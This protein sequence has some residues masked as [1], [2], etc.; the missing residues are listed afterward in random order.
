MNSIEKFK[1][2]Q[3]GVTI[4]Q[5]YASEM[6]RIRKEKGSIEIDKTA[7]RA[8][9]AAWRANNDNV[10]LD[11]ASPLLQQG[12]AQIFRSYQ[13][14]GEEI[15]TGLLMI[16]AATYV[17]DVEDT[18]HSADQRE[19][20]ED[21]A[22]QQSLLLL[23]GGLQQ[24]NHNLQEQDRYNQQQRFQQQILHELMKPTTCHSYGATTTCY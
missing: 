20:A 23:F 24:L 15:E 11:P 21:R 5:W 17:A 16:D 8:K 4:E 14:D 7:N 13:L 19:A 1:R 9:I 3:A 10:A 22:Q 12:L 6:Q 2:Q 18:Y